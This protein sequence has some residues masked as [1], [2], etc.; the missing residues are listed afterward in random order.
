MIADLRSDTL[1]K[2]TPEMRE[3]MMDAAVGDDVFGED[4]SVKALEKKC[5][6]LFGKESALFC[7]SGTMTN[8]I[9]MN[10]L[11]RPYDEVI[12]YEGAHIY[13]YEG[14]G[15][16]GNSGVSSR[17]L[18][19]DRG[20]IHA[21]D[22]EACINPDNPHYP[23]TSVIALENTVNK[24]GG[25]FY[26]MDEIQPIKQ[27]AEKHRL[28]MHLD[29]ARLFNALEETKDL[30]GEYGRVFNTIS[31]CLSKGLGAPVGSVLVM[32]KELEHAARRMRK[33]YGGGMRQAGFL[34]AAG[35]YALDHHVGRLKED[36]QRAKSLEE[37][38]QG[39]SRVEK[40]LPVDTNIVIFSLAGKSDSGKVV[41]ELEKNGLLAVAF[42]PQEIRL[43]THLDFTD[44]HL[45]M[46]VKILKNYFK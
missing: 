12:C 33:V 24:G 32:D 7:P 44:D 6:D 34:A 19:G 20:R 1:T 9:A 22:I 8:Q 27:V 39:L 43:V 35:I 2:P 10:I 21:E 26:T 38:L 29:G 14:G 28:N 41:A 17:L 18:A 3:Y 13:K 23:R 46:A 25:C 40:V 5:A 15:L 42:G 37:I 30:P 4:P 45:N 31:I 16:S 11:T 36:H